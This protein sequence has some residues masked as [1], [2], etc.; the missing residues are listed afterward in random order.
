MNGGSRCLVLA[1]LLPALPVWAEVFVRVDPGTGMSI[2]SNVAPSRVAPA[3]ERTPVPAPTVHRVAASGAVAT[4]PRVT[5]EQQHDLD[6]GRRAILLAELEAEQQDYKKAAGGGAAADV[7]ARHA[8][9][10][11]ALKR[12][13]RDTR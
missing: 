9:N 11:E 10:I 6:G 2:L 8:A 13:L 1:C 3:P 7:L 5:T 4:F 12:E